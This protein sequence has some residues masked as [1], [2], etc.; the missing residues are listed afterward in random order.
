MLEL[1]LS[2]NNGIGG[3]TPGSLFLSKPINSAVKKQFHP[4]SLTSVPGGSTISVGIKQLGDFTNSLTE[5]K[6]GDDVI[7]EGAYGEFGSELTNYQKQIWIAG[8]NSITPFV[9]MAKSLG[10]S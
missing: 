10:N 1:S 5:L 6:V 4:F 9:A 3:Y 7:V 8:G 2:S